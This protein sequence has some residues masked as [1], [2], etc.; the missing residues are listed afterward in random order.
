MAGKQSVRRITYC[1][2]CENSG[3]RSVMLHLTEEL[4]T[5]NLF[6]IYVEMF[7]EGF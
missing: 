4:V 7:S 3:K 5:L 2:T 6:G 1:N